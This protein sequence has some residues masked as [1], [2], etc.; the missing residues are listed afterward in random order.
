MIKRWVMLMSF[1]AALLSVSPALAQLPGV[2][3]DG[4]TPIEERDPEDVIRS[5]LAAFNAH[6]ADAMMA[7]LHE[8]FAWFGVDSDITTL[9][10]KGRGNFFKSMRDYFS[11]V[12]GARAEIEEIFVAGDFVTARERSYWRQGD[13]ELSQ[14]S[15]AVYEIRNGLI[16]RVWYYP[17]FE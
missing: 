2:Q 14:A 4:Q 1:G 15:L 6:N 13:A 7:N 9:E 16:Y 11:S 5:Q 12:P 3:L 8:D 17:A 10:M